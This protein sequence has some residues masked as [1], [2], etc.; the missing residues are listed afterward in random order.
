MGSSSPINHPLEWNVVS[1]A[2]ITKKIGSGSTPRG[3]QSTYLSERSTFALVRSQN[4]FD[5]RFSSDG[6]AYISDEQAQGLQNVGLS[7]GDLLLN[8]TGDGVTFVRACMVPQE[9][10]P[11]FVNQHVSIIRVDRKL[12][13]PGYVLAFLTHK[14]VKSYVESFNAGGSRRAITKGHIESFRVPLPSLPVQ[15]GIAHI[16]GTLDDKI[17]LNQQM[18]RTLEAIA[19]AIFKSWFIDFDPVHAKA[20]GRE[21]V[22]MDPE[23][24][25][26]FPDS[27]QDSPLG[28][29]PK[30][31][32]VST[33]GDLGAVICGKTPRTAQPENY[34][35]GIP[36]ITIPDMRG[37]VFATRTARELTTVGAAT[38]PKKLLPS[39]SVCVSCIATPGLVSLTSEPSHTNQQINSIVCDDGVSPYWCYLQM[40]SMSQEVIAGGSGGSATLNLN[41]GQFSALTLT[42]PPRNVQVAFHAVV[43]PIFRSVLMLEREDALLERIRDALLPRL[44]SGEIAAAKG[45][46]A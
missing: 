32:E 3:G 9:V 35:T 8:I 44:L 36:F 25:A 24:A 46:Q 18:N 4:V 7:E 34:G 2:D 19:R 12:A 42:L 21:P 17:E 43:K 39:H 15:R 38:Q 13:D 28:K 10:L 5:R 23:T 31:W 14:D 26:L 33:V 37:A 16:L 6:L 1:L 11:A 30:G 40:Q 29:I 45:E 27:F 20:E 41:K 22:G